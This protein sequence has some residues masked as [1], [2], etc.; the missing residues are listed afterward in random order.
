MKCLIDLMSIV[1]SSPHHRRV[2]SALFTRVFFKYTI[3]PNT[4]NDCWVFYQVVHHGM[5]FSLFNY[6]EVESAAEFF[7]VFD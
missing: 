1:G 4:V 5:G 3:C 6:S 7:G 2:S